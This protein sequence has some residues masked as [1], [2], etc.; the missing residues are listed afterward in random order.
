MAA[1]GTAVAQAARLRP[2]VQVDKPPRAQGRAEPV[3]LGSIARLAQTAACV[4]PAPLASPG[5][6]EL[7]VLAARPAVEALVALVV[8]G[9]HRRSTH[10]AIRMAYSGWTRKITRGHATQSVR[11]FGPA[12]FP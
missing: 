1:P 2:A 10:A 8:R 9:Q 7:V 5:R 6:V 4:R 3:L 11:G 12:R